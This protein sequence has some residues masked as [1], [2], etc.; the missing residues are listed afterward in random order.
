MERSLEKLPKLRSDK[1]SAALHY[2]T[3]CSIVYFIIKLKVISSYNI[4]NLFK[5]IALGNIS[6]YLVVLL[7]ILI[8]VKY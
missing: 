6:Y 1:V 5:E 8:T 3:I 4:A 7:S 2:Y